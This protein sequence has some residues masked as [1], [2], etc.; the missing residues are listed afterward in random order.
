[1]KFSV[2]KTD[3]TPKQFVFQAGFGFREHQSVGVLAP[4]FM[5]V[6]LLQENKTLLIVTID[7]VG[8]D[9]SFIIGIKDALKERFGLAHDEVLINFSHTHHSV[10]LTGLDTSLRQ[11]GYSLAQTHWERDHSKIDYSAD[12]EFYRYIRD[13]LLDMVAGC[14]ANL[15]D[16][17]LLLARGRSD[18]AINRR[19]PLEGGGLAWAP[20]PNAEIDKDLFVLQLQDSEG[21]L[22]SLIYAYGCHTTSMGGDDY[23]ISNDFAGYTV[24]ALE[25]KYPGV[26]PVF[27]QACAGELKPRAGSN[28]TNFFSCT[29][30]QS[31]AIGRSFAADIEGV[32]KG[33][34][35]EEVQCQ[36]RTALEDPQLPT[37]RFTTEFL[38]DI[39]ANGPG[40]YE[41]NAACNTL[42]A[43]GKGTA[44]EYRPLY[45][46]LWQL[47]PDVNLIAIEGE[48]STEYSLLIKK[49]FGNG[50]MIVLGYTN[51]VMSY[52]PTAKM[53]AEG[54]YE[55]E[56]NYFFGL[57]G[58]FV[59]EIEDIIVGRVAR[60]LRA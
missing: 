11:P 44:K 55:A 28:E 9:R 7:A 37:A 12:E 27:L 49:L 35:F 50:K 54:G 59:P 47:A 24:D 56:C 14:Y 48:V 58:P 60:M 15:T 29:P 46:A 40:S 26:L 5:S 17:K 13:E 2:A 21:M 43:L 30:E 53:L 19:L 6:V 57:Q 23:L 31:E 41:A 4:I 36:F 32:V 16:G 33:G 25:E 39:I 42:T 51:G 8:A 1:M 34:D 22:K 45:V 52:I 20:N 10:S 3:I 38:D 18:M